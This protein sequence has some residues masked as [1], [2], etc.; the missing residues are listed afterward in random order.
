MLGGGLAKAGAQETTPCEE[1]R[2]LTANGEQSDEND[3]KS[4]AF[5]GERGNFTGWDQKVEHGLL[6]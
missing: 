4:L 2:I 1:I 3:T 6:P 5:G